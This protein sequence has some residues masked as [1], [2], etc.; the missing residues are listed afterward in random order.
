MVKVVVF[1]LEPAKGEKRENGMV[2]I[3]SGI[4]NR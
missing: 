3:G 4:G 2:Y 1:V